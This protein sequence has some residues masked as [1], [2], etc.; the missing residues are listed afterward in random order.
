[1]IKRKLKTES[2]APNTDAAQDPA[3]RKR[4]DILK[5]RAEELAV[6]LAGQ[7]DTGNVIEV[8]E[9][10]LASE[11]YGIETNLIGEVYPMREYTPVPGTPD[12]VMGLINIRGRI[13]S[14]ND[15]RRFFDLPVKGLSD[16]NRV[17]VVQTARMELGILADRIVGVRTVQ[18]DT[19]Q[20]SLPTLTGIRAEYL[21]GIAPDGLVVLDVEK[22]VMDTRL[23]VNDEVE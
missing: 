8:L 18:T 23:I 14:V 4:T 13:V 7:E 6:E 10:V 22:M 12:F 21:R 11:H 3:A 5:S 17:I 2:G 20:T 9:F 15:I 1:M 19:L 16:L